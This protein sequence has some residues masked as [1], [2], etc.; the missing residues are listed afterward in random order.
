MIDIKTLSRVSSSHSWLVAP[1]AWRAAQDADAAAPAFK[2]T[3]EELWFLWK[4]VAANSKRISCEELEEESRRSFHVQLTPYLRFP[5]E[6]RAQILPAGDGQSSIALYSRSRY[7]LYD[8]GV[9]KKRVER[10]LARL[11]R[12]VMAYRRFRRRQASQ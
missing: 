11:D 7:G 8:F 6:V 9:N 10:W 5:D 3:E 2:V 12:R 4:Q 1:T